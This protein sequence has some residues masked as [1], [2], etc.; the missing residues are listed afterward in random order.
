M[1][2]KNSSQFQFETAITELNQIVDKMEKGGLSLEDSLQDFEKG[3]Q[4]IRQCQQV[5]KE[6]EQKVQIYLSTEEELQP[7]EKE[8]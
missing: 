7:Y 3:I 1:G 4:L 8:E 6:A 5:L 2:K